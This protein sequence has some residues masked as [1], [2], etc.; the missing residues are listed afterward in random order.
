MKFWRTRDRRLLTVECMTCEHL[1][2]AVNKILRDRWRMRWLPILLAE[3]A[4]R[5]NPKQPEA[6]RRK[7]KEKEHV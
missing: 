6:A 7:R 5:C 1:R 2:N 3:I 4:R